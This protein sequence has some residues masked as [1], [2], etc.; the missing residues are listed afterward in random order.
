MMTRSLG[1]GPRALEREHPGRRA[2]TRTSGHRGPETLCVP[3]LTGP[4]WLC[5]RS[6]GSAPGVPTAGGL[7]DRGSAGM[8]DGVPQIPPSAVD[9]DLS[10]VADGW[11]RS[12]SD[13]ETG[14][15][16]MEESQPRLRTPIV[17]VDLLDRP[18]D[19]DRLV[20][21]HEWASHIVPRI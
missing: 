16:R 10:A 1:E 8:T 3:H 7:D 2:T 19:W 11:D 12:M 9:V 13:L 18:P 21:A 4:H 14:M 5:G 17:A 20:R 6:A 15:W